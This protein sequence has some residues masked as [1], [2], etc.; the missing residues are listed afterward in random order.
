MKRPFFTVGIPTY[1]RAELLSRTIK[2]IINQNFNDFELIISDN[3]STDH[4]EIVARSFKDSR[5]RY[6]RQDVNVGAIQ[7]WKKVATESCGEWLV[8]HQDDDFL[9]ARFFERCHSIVKSLDDATVYLATL[10]GSQS[11]SV[12]YKPDWFCSPIALDWIGA[13]EHSVVPRNL[14]CP[15]GLFMTIGVSPAAAFRREALAKCWTPWREDCLLFNERIILAELAS[16]G[17]IVADP[18]IGGVY[19]NHPTQFSVINGVN[20]HE[21]WEVMANRLG[22]FASI[23]YPDWKT[24]FSRFLAESPPGLV[25]CWCWMAKGWKTNSPFAL[26][27]KD[28]LQPYQPPESP[29]QKLPNRL[30]WR[31]KRAAQVLVRGY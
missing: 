7:N 14:L 31:L 6:F 5:I 25:N 16:M 22:E 24:E 15:F 11:E 10:L 17:N 19:M 23:Q 1:N 30:L 20:F 2:R 27:V 21:N 18:Y 9:V 3:A 8:F 4:T 12:F 29:R 28:L 13:G 26:E